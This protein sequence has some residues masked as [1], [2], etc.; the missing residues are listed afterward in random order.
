MK[1]SPF[2]YKFVTI[3]GV[4]IGGIIGYAAGGGIGLAVGA[5]LV[6]FVSAIIDACTIN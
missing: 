5:A 2:W 4:V 3:F 1:L 6:L